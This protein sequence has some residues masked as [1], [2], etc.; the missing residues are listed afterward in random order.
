MA[1]RPA[2]SS[3]GRGQAHGRRRVGDQTV[4]GVPSL[5]AASSAQSGI[6]FPGTADVDGARSP[7]TVAAAVAAEGPDAMEVSASPGL[8]PAP[9]PDPSILANLQTSGFRH[10]TPFFATA[11]RGAQFIRGA[12]A[13]SDR[14]ILREFSP[15]YPLYGLF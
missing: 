8:G 1:R 9:L 15:W 3:S 5:P 2:S 4:P 11:A 14:E 13:E 7:R 12:L 6:R 10:G